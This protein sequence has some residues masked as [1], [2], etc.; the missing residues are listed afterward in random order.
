MIMLPK[1]VIKNALRHKFR[2]TLTILGIAVAVG[3]FGLLRT[4]ITSWYA[5]VEA[6]ATDRLITRHAVSFIFPLPYSYGDKI[7]KAQ[8]VENVTYFNWFQGVYKDKSEFFPRM[9]CDPQTIFDVYPEFIV[10]PEEKEAFQKERNACVLGEDIA[11][12]YNLKVGDAMSIEGDI[13]P[14]KWDFVIRAIYKPR[15]EAVDG[16]QMFFHWQYLDE[17]MKQDMPTRAGYIGWYAAKISDPNQAAAI[18]EYVDGLF[19]NSSA[20]TKTETERAFNQGFIGAYSAIITGINIMA[21]MIIGVILMVLTNTMIMS[22]RERSREYA[23]MKTL[24]F[25]GKHILGVVSGESIFISILGGAAGYGLTLLF[26]GAF[27]IVVPKNFFPVFILEPVTIMQEF[28]FAILVGV[29]AGII[30][31]VQA[32]RIKIVD[33]LRYAG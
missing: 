2:T 31:V 28:G 9:A 17:R 20:E 24:G 12:K 19:A 1:L 32:V 3:A 16:T 15:S 23:V 30:P 13:Y 22:A 33:G 25:T 29:I 18:S 21:F 11:K 7:A 5:A 14:G 10:T 8:G 27:A 26:V 4:V 6:T